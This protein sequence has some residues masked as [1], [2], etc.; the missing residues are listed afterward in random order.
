VEGAVVV[1]G[2]TGGFVAAVSAALWIIARATGGSG[3]DDEK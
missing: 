1:L 2:L 3:E